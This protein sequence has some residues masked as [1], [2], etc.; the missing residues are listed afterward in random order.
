MKSVFT[1][2][3]RSAEEPK[4]DFQFNKE[5]TGTSH[6]DHIAVIRTKEPRNIKEIL[7]K[8]AKEKRKTE[9]IE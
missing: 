9:V 2:A 3:T 7:R 5:A 4:L 1:D 8:T 6:A